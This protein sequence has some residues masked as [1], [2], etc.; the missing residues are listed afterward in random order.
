MYRLPDGKSYKGKKYT[1]EAVKRDVRKRRYFNSMFF[2][3]EGNY[4]DCTE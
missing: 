1:I 4:R 3:L 2:F